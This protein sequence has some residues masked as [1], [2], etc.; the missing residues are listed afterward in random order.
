MHQI[1]IDLSSQQEVQSRRII[2]LMVNN[3][4]IEQI[5]RPQTSFVFNFEEQ[6]IDLTT[7]TATEDVSTDDSLCSS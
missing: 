7:E 3:V 1:D 5:Q 6:P 2:H 4:T